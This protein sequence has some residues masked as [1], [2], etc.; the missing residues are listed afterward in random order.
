MGSEPK[1]YVPEIGTDS[2]EP[3]LAGRGRDLQA[4][5]VPLTGLERA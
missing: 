4:D 3:G 1:S 2:T 5:Q